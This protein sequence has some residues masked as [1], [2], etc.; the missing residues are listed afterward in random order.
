MHSY[1]LACLS[2]AVLL[3]PETNAGTPDSCS[4]M[5]PR[6]LREAVQ[7]QYAAYRLPR[8]S[9]NV[10]DD[11]RVNREHGGSGCLG[12]T[13]GRY[14]GGKSSDY[15][16][17]LYSSAFDDRALLVVA[18]QSGASQWRLELL[19]DWGGGRGVL[20]VESARPGKYTRFGGLDGPLGEPGELSQFI[21][22]LPGIVSGRVESSGVAYFFTAKHWVHVWVSD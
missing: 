1:F 13:V 9:D 18:S 3:S 21:S 15:A 14:R 6:G 17:L 16:L 12:V 20:Y 19:R 22:A 2:S 7:R 10:P 5:L 11:I 8:E 4:G